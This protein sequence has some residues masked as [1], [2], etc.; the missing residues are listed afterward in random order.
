MNNLELKFGMD[1]LIYHLINSDNLKDWQNF[2][3]KLLNKINFLSNN[4]KRFFFADK[5]LNTVFK[6]PSSKDIIFEQNSL[7]AK[8]KLAFF[9][10]IDNKEQ[11]VKEKLMYS[12]VYAKNLVCASMKLFIKIF[13]EK[14]FGDVSISV[15]TLKFFIQNQILFYETKFAGSVADDNLNRDEG[16]LQHFD[17]LFRIEGLE[18]YINEDFKQF[19]FKQIIKVL[20]VELDLN[21]ELK[22]ETMKDDCF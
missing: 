1:L 12:F 11:L 9:I 15:A 16:D 8:K 20:S 13:I 6:I 18:G 10:D 4:N 7:E 3:T 21:Q 5:V 14:S 17:L 22:E 19:L 2:V